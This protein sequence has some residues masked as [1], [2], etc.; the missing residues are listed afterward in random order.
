MAFP[1]Q[2]LRDSSAGPVAT[3]TAPGAPC[4]LLTIELDGVPQRVF[5]H[6]PRTLGEA[7]RQQ[8]QRCFIELRAHYRTDA[9]A[10]ASLLA[11]RNH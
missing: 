8:L 6:A 2:P 5:R 11:Y 7:C 1:T 10:S 9:E 3:L 4:E